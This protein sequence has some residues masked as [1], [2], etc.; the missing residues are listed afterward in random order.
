MVSKPAA[1]LAAMSTD[2]ATMTAPFLGGALLGFLHGILLN[3]P[4][5]VEGSGH[6]CG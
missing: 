6:A 4:Q 1:M 5:V 3:W 2:T